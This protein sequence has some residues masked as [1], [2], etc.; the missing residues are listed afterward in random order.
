MTIEAR[1]L[2]EPTK[3]KTQARV[4]ALVF[5]VF[6]AGTALSACGQAKPAAAGTLPVATAEP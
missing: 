2:T 3:R 6:S 4:A 1:P 5:I